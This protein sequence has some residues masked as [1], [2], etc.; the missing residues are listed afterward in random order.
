M[1]NAPFFFLLHSCLVIDCDS[2]IRRSFFFPP[3]FF[4]FVSVSC[5]CDRDDSHRGRDTAVLWHSNISRP[6][7]VQLVLVPP[8]NYLLLSLVLLSKETTR[9]LWGRD[10]CISV[11]TTRFHRSN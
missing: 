10:R 7:N 8:S 11:A 5:A 9:P 2:C 1:P 6:G 4:A 3:F